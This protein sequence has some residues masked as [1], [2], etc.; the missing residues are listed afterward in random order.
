MFLK[1]QPDQTWK[2]PQTIPGGFLLR[3]QECRTWT[4]HHGPKSATR[5]KEPSF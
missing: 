5:P 3:E 1:M 2:I 4:V